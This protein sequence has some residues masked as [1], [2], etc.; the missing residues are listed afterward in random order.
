MALP[1]INIKGKEYTMVKDRILF[2]NETYENGSI[3]NRLVSA[4]DDPR[5]VIESTVVP[6]VSNPH[7]YFRDYSQAVVGD[8][9]INKQAALENAST[10]AVGRALALMGIGVIESVASADEIKKATSFGKP[11]NTVAQVEKATSKST[12][13]EYGANRVNPEI[14]DDDI[15]KF[16]GPVRTTENLSPEAVAVADHLIHFVPLTQ[17]RNKQIQDRLAE[18]VKAKTLDRRKLQVFLDKEHDGKRSIDVPAD[19]WEQTIK[20]IE[21]AVK[22]GAE[23]I[24]TLFKKGD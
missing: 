20:K 10:S 18:L 6:D 11:V 4:P 9:L 8:G 13:F 15:P 22:D 19:K 17:D 3:T 23:S 24:K 7:R 21:D 2:F 1:T 12:S 14:T 16:D 5:V